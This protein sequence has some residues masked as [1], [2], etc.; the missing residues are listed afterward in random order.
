MLGQ[1]P[2][3]SPLSFPP[4]T[5]I[6]PPPS[7]PEKRKA[8]IAA[9]VAKELEENIAFQN[10]TS[11]GRKAKQDAKKNAAQTRV[12][13][14]ADQP[15]TTRKRTSS[16]A[17]VSEPAKKARE[18]EPAESDGEPEPVAA[19]KSK[20]KARQYAAPSIDIDSDDA[21][22]VIVKST[23]H[24]DFTNL[25]ANNKSTS[26]APPAKAKASYADVTRAKSN[27][28]PK[29]A[30][31]VA[32]SASENDTAT[33]SSSEEDAE[34]S[35]QTFD[36]DGPVDV[37]EFLPEFPQVVST[38]SKASANTSDDSESHELDDIAPRVPKLPKKNTSGPKVKK[39]V[40]EELFESDWDEVVAPVPKKKSASKSK[41]PIVRKVDSDSEDSMPDA[42]HRRLV[43]SDIDMSDMV[44]LPTG[45]RHRRSSMASSH[46]S[47]RSRHGS[48]IDFAEAMADAVVSIP[49]SR[50]S[51]MGS[52]HSSG[53]DLSV[54]ASEMGS[55]SGVEQAAPATK[56]KT[57]KV[58]AHRQKQADSEKPEIKLSV[59][60][61]HLTKGKA[62]VD[63]SSRPES[64]WDISARLVLPGPNKDIGLTAQHPE[65]QTVLRDTMTIIKIFMLFVDAYPLMVTRAGFGR[66]RLI[67]AAEARPAASHILERL[68]KDPTFGATLA[69]IPIDR[70]NILRGNLKRCSVSCVLAF[71]ALADLQP[72]Q[73]K[74]GVEEL[75][76][77]H[78]YIFP[79][80]AGQFQFTQ[81]FRHGSI[82]FVL[83]E[84]LFTSV[85]FVTQNIERFAS[86]YE[87]KPTE[88]ELPDSMLALVAT[89]IYAALVEYRM[90]GRHQNTP[91]TEDAYEDTYR[92]H[93]STLEGARRT[94]P[95]ATHRIMHALFTEV[96]EGNKIVHT[97]SGSS[98][99][100]IQLVDL[101]DS[102]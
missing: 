86:K 91:F 64:S 47:F 99:T 97:A 93:V 26:K 67:E 40:P 69:P 60:S 75:L 92:N 54:P 44:P 17:E 84:E 51:S 74:E 53:R 38:H 2:N 78:R 18:M 1:K 20:A 42:P 87:K 29:P 15:S 41:A 76:Q 98:S 71:F 28:K 77:D 57:Q 68:L 79:R 81:P 22:S 34:D 48:D 72:H 56:K 94:A 63:A 85:S 43:D 14:K 80:T 65:L 61:S 8:T 52:A 10:Q 21:E 58:S 46:S 30:K 24:I 82:R 100:L 35:D 25:P 36:D 13:W 7:F 70:M 6:H 4:T 88:R 11:G 32:D 33:S 31:I 50:R 59:P 5:S 3:I 96:T 55:D 16:T 102:D 95:H 73:V 19:S 9:K 23:R 45:P 12:V 66:P 37:D 39:A 49:R 62:A 83:K 89:A 27:S 90:T 101:P